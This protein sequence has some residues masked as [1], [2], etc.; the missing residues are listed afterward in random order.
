V[1]YSWPLGGGNKVDSGFKDEPTRAQL[2]A[3]LAQLQIMRN[4]A[5]IEAAKDE[6]EGD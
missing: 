2:D 5:P 3:M 4:V 1:A 6:A